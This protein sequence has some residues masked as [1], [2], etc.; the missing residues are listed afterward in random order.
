VNN[1]QRAN[2]IAIKQFR[3][4]LSAMLEDIRDIDIKCLNKAV[5]EG[6]KVAKQLTNVSEGGNIV[7]FTT[8]DGVHVNFTTKTTRVGGFMRKSWR[9]APAVKSKSGGVTKSIVNN[10]DYSSYVNYGHRIVQSGVTKGFVKGQFMLEKAI[11]KV[12]KVLV[13][14]FNKEVERVNREHDK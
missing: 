5:N 4:E 12:D 9:S 1:N 7:D 13:S 6:V 2:E 3:K 14:E 11:N 8:R 10:A